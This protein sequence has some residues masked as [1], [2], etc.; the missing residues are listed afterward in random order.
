MER[1]FGGWWVVGGVPAGGSDGVLAVDGEGQAEELDGVEGDAGGDLG[2]RQTAYEG[3]A[4][5][6]LHEQRRHQSEQTLHQDVVLVR[7]HGRTLKRLLHT[8]NTVNTQSAFHDETVFKI[9]KTSF[10]VK[11]FSFPFIAIVY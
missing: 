8:H 2:Q 11:K 5:Q 10:C 6:L 9:F 1:A 4:Q 3:T 7:E